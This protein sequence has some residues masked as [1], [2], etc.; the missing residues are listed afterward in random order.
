VD[1]EAIGIRELWVEPSGVDVHRQIESF[2]VLEG[3]LS[4]TLDGR[5]VSAPEGSWVEVAAGA[6]HAVTGTARCLNIRTP[7]FG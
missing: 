7:N 4:L 3:T 6:A 5:E 2:Y 1:I